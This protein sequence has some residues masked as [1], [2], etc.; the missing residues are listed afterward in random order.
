MLRLSTN[1]NQAPL[2]M[3]SAYDSCCLEVELF[4]DSKHKAQERA[5][6]FLDTV[7]ERPLEQVSLWFWN[8]EFT[9]DFH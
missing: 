2:L 4:G 5:L 3:V 6:V 7:N 8:N 1:Q 9:G